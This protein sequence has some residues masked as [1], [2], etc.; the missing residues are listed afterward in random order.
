MTGLPISG[1]SL[2]EGDALGVGDGMATAPISGWR[3]GVGV[4]NGAMSP[5]TTFLLPKPD[6][7]P[8][9]PTK[10]RNRPKTAA[11]AI[12]NRR[13]TPAQP[14]GH[15]WVSTAPSARSKYLTQSRPSESLNRFSAS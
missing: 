6:V 14:T 4:A 15:S 1:W 8:N 10:L 7:T 3:S 9:S 13:F 2:G 5:I 12:D 11:D